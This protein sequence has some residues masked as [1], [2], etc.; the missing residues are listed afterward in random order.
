MSYEII[1]CVKRV[2]ETAEADVVIDDSG[3]GI[4]DR[5]LAYVI[6]EWDNYA[7]EEAIRIK[8]EF[9]G[10]VT[11]LTM[12]PEESDEVLRRCLAM[13]ADSGIRLTDEAFDGSDARAT[14]AV[15]HATIKDLNFDLVFAGVQAGDDGWG[16]VGGMLAE[17][18]DV[19]HAT[20][21][22][23]IEIAD[24]TAKIRRELEGGLE[25]SL[26]IG[27][28]AVLTIQTGINEPRYVS[29]MGIRKARNKEIRELHLEDT[30]LAKDNVGTAGSFVT[31]E[32]LSLPVSDK[33]AEI[34]EGSPEEA[35]EKLAEILKKGGVI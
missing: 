25:E 23:N 17:M 28:P 12:G 34:L 9:G 22:T 21:V 14:A 19:Q 20:L 32:G 5:D 7:V 29:I 10:S 16:Q 13:G 31:T 3:K 26:E 30:G 35:S 33:Q 24:K 8:E 6:N 1:V 11:V 27:L 2:P 18:L 15:L 4:V